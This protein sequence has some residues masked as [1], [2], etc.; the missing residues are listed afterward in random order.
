MLRRS[1]VTAL[2][3]TFVI[4]PLANSQPPAALRGFTS[5][6]A[7]A[8]RQAEEKFKAIPKPD[9]LREYM[10]VITQAPHHA[11]SANSRKVAE[12]VLSRFKAAG[13]NA[14]IEQFEALEI[15]RSRWQARMKQTPTPPV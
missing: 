3:F 13:L 8:E 14:S 1:S 9:N 12:Y 4:S 10:R 6:G 11:G 5:D 7:A 15:P 2:L